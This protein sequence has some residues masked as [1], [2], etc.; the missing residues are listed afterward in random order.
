VVLEN[1]IFVYKFADMS[2]VEAVTT[3]AN[4]RGIVALNVGETNNEVLAT[5]APELGHV[6]ISLYL[7]SKN[8]IIKAHEN[9]IAA[10]NL[11]PDGRLIATASEKGTLVRLI[12]TESGNPLCEFR[13][14]SSKADI[15]SIVFENKLKF[16]AVASTSST[17]HVFVIEK[18]IHEQLGTNQ[19]IGYQEEGKQQQV[20]SKKGGFMSG[21]FGKGSYM[22]STTS[23]MQFKIKETSA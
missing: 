9:S 23:F 19:G 21:L 13:R 10:M 11:T 16:L 5:P 18:E 22:N 8:H 4:P 1:K 12:N 20:N 15:T 17:V 7:K 3:C 6:R 14:G 2:L